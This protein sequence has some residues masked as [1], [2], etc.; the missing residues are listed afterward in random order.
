MLH[1]TPKAK[2]LFIDYINSHRRAKAHEI[3]C[4][5]IKNITCN[6]EKYFTI[7]L[8]EKDHADVVRLIINNDGIMNKR[9]MERWIQEN[10]YENYIQRKQECDID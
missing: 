3:R 4:S 7:E 5:K 2:E 8:K 10:Y 9:I 1:I 6:I